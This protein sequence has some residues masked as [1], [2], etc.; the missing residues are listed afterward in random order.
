MQQRALGRE[1]LR[2]VLP[3]L[4]R[5][6]FLESLSKKQ[7]AAVLNLAQLVEL[8]RGEV[9]AEEGSDSDAFFIVAEGSV[10]VRAEVGGEQLSVARLTPGDVVG[11]LGLLLGEPR[12][13]S[14]A[15]LGETAVLR[16][17]AETFE[18]LMAD[19]PAFSQA[20]NRLL[21][22]R[23]RTSARTVP[24]SQAD[25]AALAADDDALSLLPRDFCERHRVVPLQVAEGELV[26][27]CEEAPGTPVLHAIRNWLPALRLRAVQIDRVRLSDL[28]QR[29]G[30][31]EEGMQTA[32]G[33]GHVQSALEAGD[34]DAVFRHMVAE[35]ASDVHL[36]G[37]QVPCWRI[38]GEIRPIPGTAALGHD[39][40][41]ELLGRVVP[42]EFLVEYDA[43]G[44]VDLAYAVEGSGRFRLNLFRDHRGA[45]AVARHIPERLLSIEQLGLPMAVARLCELKSGLV[46]VTGPTGSGKSTTL[47]AMIDWINRTRAGHILTLEDPIEFVHGSKR[48]LV[49]QRDI[50]NHSASFSRAL[51]A[52]LREDPDIVLIGEMRDLETVSLALETANTGHLVFGTLHT[53]TAISTIDRIVDQ[54]PPS[55]QAQIRASL[56][57]ALRGVVAQTLCKRN[58]GGR[59]AAVEVLVV[60]AA[61]A[62]QIRT[63][64][65]AQIA[66][67]MQ[68]GRSQGMTTLN[69]ELLRLVREGTISPDEAI[70]RAA[71]KGELSARLGRS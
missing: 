21:A 55:Q 2:R 38:D 48:C 22:R 31:P 12:S 30:A 67:I 19:V 28:L 42:D 49:N 24:L 11:E 25:G 66:T 23:L 64:K 36:S 8:S 13:A 10:D 32:A 4:G 5:S 54:F 56:A 70:S 14:L 52:A 27:G 37:G 29:V 7:L 53:S 40:V 45:C 51:K 9:L 43:T 62:N 44:D 26:L 58:G 71:D 68:T 39:Q 47:A 35:G 59:V 1:D 6:V 63:A 20:L 17:S 16:F 46:L 69:H 18:Q 34:I 41:R 33:P 50:G 57:D 15:A 60:N 61:V 65:V 3:A